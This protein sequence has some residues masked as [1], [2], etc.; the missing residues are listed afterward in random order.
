MDLNSY[1][2]NYII[3]SNTGG[4]TDVSYPETVD[5]IRS[6]APRIFSSQNRLFTLADYQ[7]FIKKN[8]S[9][10][11]KDLYL[12]NNDTYTKDYLKYYYDIGLDSPQ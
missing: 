4:S 8:F 3:A 7:Q 5:S 2:L 6:N 9:S 12:C 1:G 11:V 10:Y